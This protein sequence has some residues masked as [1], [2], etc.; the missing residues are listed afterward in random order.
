[1]REAY[2][3]LLIELGIF[4]L[5]AIFMFK[6]FKSFLKCLYHFLI[7]NFY[8]FSKRQWSEHFDKSVKMDEYCLIVMVLTLINVLII[9]FW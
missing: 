5:T 6:G 9:R 3:F 8:V 4:S 7:R 1:M 2:F